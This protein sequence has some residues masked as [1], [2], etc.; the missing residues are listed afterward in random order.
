LSCIQQA[1]ALAQET[2]ERYLQ[3]NVLTALGHCLEALGRLAEAR[4]AYQEALS[5]RREMG[6]P[7]EATE[8]QAGL[9]RVCLAG[10]DP[11]RATGHVEDILTYLE[12]G[13]LEG[14]E[15]P[16][17]VYLSCYRV[18]QAMDDPR[19]RKVIDEAYQLLQDIATK[20]TDED[21][22]HS[23]LQNVAAHREI[24]SAHDRR[25]HP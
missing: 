25:D 9:A 18:L 4:A 8:A 5:L 11:V 1:L 21:L 6:H 16:L 3:A 14:T 2:G 13:T 19:A 12:S 20:I 22:R 23:F 10:G 7:H 24:A 17:L 15:H